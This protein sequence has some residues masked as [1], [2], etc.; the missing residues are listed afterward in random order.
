MAPST[1]STRIRSRY[2]DEVALLATELARLY[3]H[4]ALVID[5]LH[6][7]LAERCAHHPLLARP[8]GW[9]L[10]LT[11]SPFAHAVVRK[12]PLHAACS[13]RTIATHALQADVTLLLTQRLR[14]P[15]RPTSRC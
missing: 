11:S 15:L 9:A 14:V 2:D 3:H 6:R 12:A 4:D 10:V 8:I 7:V 1:G 5:G 13:L